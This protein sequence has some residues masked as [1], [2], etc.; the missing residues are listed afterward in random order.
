[1][2]TVGLLWALC[3]ALWFVAGSI[4]RDQ[5][6]DGTGG[7]T[8]SAP[9]AIPL[10]FAFLTVLLFLTAALAAAAS[11]ALDANPMSAREAL[12]EA[13]DRLRAIAGLAVVVTVVDIAFVALF[14]GSVALAW[15]GT[16]VALAWTI[17]AYF[18]GA[19]IAIDGLDAGSALRRSAGLARRHWREMLGGTLLFF[20][21][22]ALAGFVFG[23]AFAV[24]WTAMPE[25]WMIFVA[26][27]AT[28]AFAV[29]FA[30]IAIAGTVFTASLYRF[31]GG[32]QGAADLASLVD[33]PRVNPPGGL[34]LAGRIG[35]G[36][37]ALCVITGIA[38]SMT[39]D[40]PQHDW[41]RES[42]AAEARE[43]RFYTG[44]PETYPVD[45]SV[46]T[47][48]V[49]R[50]RQVGV[51]CDSWTEANDYVVLAFEAHPSFAPLVLGNQ[52]SFQRGPNGIY[53]ELGQPLA[54]PQA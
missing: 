28:A 36:L 7:G 47:P 8:L 37:L 49:Y 53:L 45:V 13:W 9:V 4:I 44:Y 25:V 33:P 46:G 41:S 18:A 22:G 26:L 40:R 54:A 34:W 43:G 17:A 6:N 51:I 5:V 30:R 39:P 19:A 42:I 48:V 23:F 14:S 20:A 38:A 2:I 50:N 12:A 3:L 11:A 35:V 29:V 10:T 1:M 32:G 21:L 16:F 27:A 52:M 24:L 31:A 15:A